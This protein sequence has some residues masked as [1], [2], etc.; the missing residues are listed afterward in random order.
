MFQYVSKSVYVEEVVFVSK[1]LY[2]IVVGFSE[3]AYFGS[4]FQS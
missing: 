1:Y 2:S 4:D 3:T